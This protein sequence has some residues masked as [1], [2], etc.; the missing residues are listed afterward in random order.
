MGERSG[1][2]VGFRFHPELY[3]TKRVYRSATINGLLAGSLL[4]LRRN[5]CSTLTQ[6]LVSL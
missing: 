4:Y 2:S 3:F 1:L 5:Y 6:Y